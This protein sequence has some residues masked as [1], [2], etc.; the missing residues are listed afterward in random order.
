MLDF[1]VGSPSSMA[2]SISEEEEA[3]HLDCDLSA[4]QIAK[5]ADFAKWIVAMCV[6]GFDVELG[7]TIELIF[8]ESSALDVAEQKAVSY[9]AFPDCNSGLAG[10]TVYSFRFKSTTRANFLYGYVCFR[11][12]S[13]PVS[14]RGYFQKV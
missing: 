9:L 5:H 14:A 1:D 6:V 3:D 13:D 7:Q 8:P 4:V 2:F 10:D 11:Q 12:R